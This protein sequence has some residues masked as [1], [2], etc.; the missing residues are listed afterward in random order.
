MMRGAI[1]EAAGGSQSPKLVQ[2]PAGT[3][4]C[5][6]Y[7]SEQQ[8]VAEC[9]KKQPFGPG[10]DQGASNEGREHQGEREKCPEAATETLERSHAEKGSA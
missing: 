10:K 3:R 7:D 8:Q 4:G 5:N 9:Q 1:S 6:G 2:Y